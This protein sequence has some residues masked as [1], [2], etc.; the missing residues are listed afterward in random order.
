M[1]SETEI[2]LEK[3]LRARTPAV[4]APAGLHDDIMMAVRTS[5]DSGEHAGRSSGRWMPFWGFAVAVMVVTCW[6]VFQPVEKP[7][8]LTGAGAA[9]EQGQSLAQT[10]PA[11]A[12]SP[13][14]NEM[15]L[16]KQDLNGAMQ[17]VIESVPIL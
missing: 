3:Q 11:N 9:L 8:G 1:R 15:E 6:M 5:R 2:E 4:K 14:S 10:A 13:L 17:F 7:Q 12:L 16:L